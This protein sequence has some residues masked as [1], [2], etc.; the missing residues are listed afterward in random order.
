MR[1]IL[2]IL[3]KEFIQV[4]R[5]RSMLPIIFVVPM[6][7]LL[8]LA[9][10]VTFEIKNINLDVVNQDKSP[11]SRELIS[12]FQGSPF[13]TL[14]NF[15]DD[16]DQ[17]SADLKSGKAHQVLIIPQHFERD[18]Y[19]EDK[20][21]LQLITNAIDGSAAALMNA[22]G[23][24][25]IRDYNKEL[26]VEKLG[27]NFQVDPITISYTYWFNPELNYTTY[28]VPGILVLLVTMIGIFLSGMNVVREKEMGTI[29]QIN[30]SPIKKYQF[31]CGKLLPFWFIALFELAFGLLLARLIFH[32]PLLGSVWLIFAVAAI[33][34]LAVMGIGLFLATV[35][36][37][38]QQSMFLSWFFMVIFIL[39][40][41]LFTPVEN[42]PVWVQHLNTINPIAYFIHIM[43]MVMLK[44]SGFE[45]ILKPF[46]SIT[47]YALC[48]LS[49]AVWRYK[50]VV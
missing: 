49:L 50:K 40:S 11:V 28:M 17:A 2:V 43:R 45:D 14:R 22:Y 23:L 29:E 39:M 6:V 20:A 27:D 19:K 3:R 8:V 34:L 7:Q 48:M 42:M 33:Y 10:A 30:V 38:Q 41:G 18:L 36:N 24:S 35:S 44:G 5:N 4:F 31:I 16:Y 32:I 25:I 9:F 13:F 47:V 1:T 26:I 21:M 15:Y 37:T 12:K 46:A